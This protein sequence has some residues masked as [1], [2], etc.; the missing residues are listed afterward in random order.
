MRAQANVATALKGCLR[1]LRLPA[2][3]D[4]YE[5]EARKAQQESLSYERYLL[6]LAQRECEDRRNHRIERHLK[7]SKLP[8]EKSLARMSH[9]AIRLLVL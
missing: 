4:C 7:A 1:E 5:E 9:M 8:L 6:E 3:R 2:F